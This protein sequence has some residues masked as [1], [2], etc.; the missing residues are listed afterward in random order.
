MAVNPVFKAASFD[1]EEVETI[2]LDARPSAP[3]SG[4]VASGWSSADSFSAT[5]NDY[6]VEFK[7]S[8]TPQVIKFLDS[9]GPFAVYRQHFLTGKEGK[10]SYICLGSN[11]PLCTELGNRPEDKRAF[12]IV[13]LSVEG[14]QRQLLIATPRLFKALHSIHF[15][16]QGPL[17]K[18]YWALSRTGTKQTTQYNINPVK[19]RDLEEDWNINEQEALEFLKTAELYDKS[20]IKETSFAELLDIAKS[21]S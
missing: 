2:D 8:E 9:D 15:T 18:N 10:K 20:V 5:N 21:L 3:T 1:E 11:C 19:G 14:Y 12:T 13:N 7:H 17:D 6:P 4:A 16:P